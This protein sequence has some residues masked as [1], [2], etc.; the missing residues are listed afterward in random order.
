M[1]FHTKFN[2]LWVAYK[3]HLAMVKQFAGKFI[4][5]RKR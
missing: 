1:T 3:D 5:Y 4:F 2:V